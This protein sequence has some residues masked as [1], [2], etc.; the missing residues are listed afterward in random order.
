MKIITF[1]IYYFVFIPYKLLFK[2]HPPILISDNEEFSDITKLLEND[3]DED[4][5]YAWNSWN[6]N[7][8]SPYKVKFCQKEVSQFHFLVQKFL[9]NMYVLS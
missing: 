2:D 8:N 7:T 3:T 4:N 1:V 6:T 5:P 9:C